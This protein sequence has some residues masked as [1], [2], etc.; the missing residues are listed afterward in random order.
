MGKGKRKGERRK[1][2]MSYE[3]E[4]REELQLTGDKGVAE[5]V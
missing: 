2:L 3:G 1:T 5:K 4:K